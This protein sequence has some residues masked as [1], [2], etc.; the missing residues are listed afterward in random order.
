MIKKRNFVR[1]NALKY[2]I[3]KDA[4]LA[5]TNA[6]IQLLETAKLN[7]SNN[8]DLDNSI[9]FYATQK[10]NILI[11]QKYAMMAEETKGKYLRCYS[12]YFL[13]SCLMPEFEFQQTIDHRATTEN[14]TKFYDKNNEWQYYKPTLPSEFNKHDKKPHPARCH[15]LTQPYDE[16]LATAGGKTDK[17]EEMLHGVFY[18]RNRAIGYFGMPNNPDYS[19]SVFQMTETEML[20]METY[21]KETK[22]KEWR[23]KVVVDDTI[24]RVYLKGVARGDFTSQIDRHEG[25]LHDPPKKKGLIFKKPKF[26][27]FCVYVS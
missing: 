14:K 17:A 10:Q 8:F 19:K 24:F 7:D 15:E 25:L 20:E 27:F 16:T 23:D 2:T 11:K 12:E 21:E 1:E 9:A 22:F 26:S 4:M 5:K 13:D 6:K 18:T 3:P